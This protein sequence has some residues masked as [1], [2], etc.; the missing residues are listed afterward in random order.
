MVDANFLCHQKKRKVKLDK[1]REG[2]RPITLH[3]RAKARK[4]ILGS[5][6]TPL[7]HLSVN[8][9]QLAKI[10]KSIPD[11][12]L[13]WN[14]LGWSCWSKKLQIYFKN[15]DFCEYVEFW[16]ISLYFI[17][18]QLLLNWS[19]NLKIL[20]HMCDTYNCDYL[21]HS[22][23]RFNLIDFQLNTDFPSQFCVF[24]CKITWRYSKIGFSRKC[25]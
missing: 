21:Q 25:F 2:L 10:K 23:F 8:G 11:M 7:D 20:L 3:F 4:L 5:I 9:L 6:G 12:A 17:F 14:W 13:P 15:Y 18:C 1:V 22:T 19:A 24:Y 16:V